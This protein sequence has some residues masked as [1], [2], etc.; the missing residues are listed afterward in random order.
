MIFKKFL[1]ED[2]K[3]EAKG[4]IKQN[5]YKMKGRRAVSEKLFLHGKQ[6][7]CERAVG[8]E[9]FFGAAIHRGLPE[10]LF[11]SRKTFLYRFV[12]ADHRAIVHNKA[13]V[14]GVGVEEK[15]EGE[16]EEVRGKR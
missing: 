1:Q 4:R 14:Q 13:V 6:A 16:N 8:S 11:D 12:I 9:I 3:Y 7:H 5:L 15:G 10:E 2:K